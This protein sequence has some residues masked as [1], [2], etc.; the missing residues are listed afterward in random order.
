MRS[1][2]DKMRAALDSKAKIR[3]SL[4]AIGSDISEDTPL[5]EYGDKVKDMS[6]LS[7]GYDNNDW[8]ADALAYAKKIQD[9][10]DA[11]VT[12]RYSTYQNDNK[13]IFLPV[14]DMSNITYTEYM[15]RGCGKLI[16]V[17]HMDMR[18]TTAIHSMFYQCYDLLRASIT[19]SGDVTIWYAFYGCSRLT[20]VDLE[21]D[22]YPT[23]MQGTFQ[24]CSALT[25]IPQL[26]TSK[27]T[28]MLYFIPYC[29]SL[30]RVE[31]LDFSSVTTLT[32]WAQYTEHV[33]Y[34]R[35]KNLGKSSLTTYPISWVSAWGA[36]SEENRQTLVDSLL[37][38]SYDRA[39]NG[40][41]TATIQLHANAK[42]R[43]TDEEI[44]AITA[45]GYTIS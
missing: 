10:W 23:N 15:F 19:L 18:N 11:S 6:L 32:N 37:T 31:G 22:F 35:I 16:L 17:P 12:K 29:Y 38:D 39:A 25:A 41:A 21:G 27:V 42:A 2:A 9:E 7:I 43:L 13:L 1:T 33:A 40:M 26:D 28:N 20:E 3:D 34:M 24:G 14:V 4:S 5:S 44:A 45:K 36:D 8:I 30:T